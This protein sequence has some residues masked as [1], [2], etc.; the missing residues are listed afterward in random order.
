MTS[1]APTESLAVAAEPSEVRGLSMTAA[2]YGLGVL[3]VATVFASVVRQILVLVTEPLKQ[4]LQLSDTQIGLVNGIALSLVS[5][6]AT[7][8]MGWL[9]DRMDRRLLL[10]ACIV[11][12]S[13]FTA[14]CGLANSFEVLFICSMGI[15][16]GEAVLGPISYTLIA[17]LFPRDRWMQANYVYFVTALL[18]AAAG[19]AF[20]GGV[21]SLVDASHASLPPALSKLEPW[22]VA[23]FAAAIPGAFIAIAVVLIRLARSSAKGTQGAAEGVVSY[24]RTHARTFLGV[25]AGF[26]T[27][28]CAMGTVAAWM[29][30]VAVRIFHETPANTG[31]KFG[32]VLAVAAVLGALVSFGLNRVLQPRIGKVT[33]LRVAQIGAAL[34]ALALTSYPFIETTTQLL[35]AATVQLAATICAISLSPTVMQV[36]APAHIRGRVIAIGGL[37]GMT[38]QS[39]GPV[40][41]GIVSDQ[42]AQGPHALLW[43]ILIV[44]APAYLIGAALLQFA[45]PTLL[46]TLAAVDAR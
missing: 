31:F 15:A 25:F 3:V 37:I 9:S 36:M 13:V 41:V 7:F 27:I 16:V 21:I 38:F 32:F 28:A 10:A 24:L 4:S 40:L 6:L 5:M 23:L 42:F 2:W 43:S 46:R 45:A 39:L 34:A 19:M 22:R 14:A 17:D 11:I 33:A 20:S 1:N 44:A 26:G 12:W 18:G 30:V 35:V 8:P 29:P